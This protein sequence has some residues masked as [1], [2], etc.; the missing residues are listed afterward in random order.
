MLQLPMIGVKRKSE[1]SVTTPINTGAQHAEVMPE[2]IP[3]INVE[4]TSVFPAFVS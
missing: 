3:S 2:N 4:S 1:L